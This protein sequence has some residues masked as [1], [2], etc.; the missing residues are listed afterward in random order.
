MSE[1]GEQKEEEGKLTV[2]AVT[3]PAEEKE[4]AESV[5]RFRSKLKQQTSGGKDGSELHHRRDIRSGIRK[6]KTESS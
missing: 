4:Q 6:R 3:V 2:K 5:Y 1:G